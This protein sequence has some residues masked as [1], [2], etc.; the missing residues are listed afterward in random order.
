MNLKDELD[1]ALKHM[2][3]ALRILHERIARVEQW[4]VSQEEQ[5]KCETKMP[6]TDKSK[7]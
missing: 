6:L 1:D 3:E 5:K 2:A 7:Q 4:M